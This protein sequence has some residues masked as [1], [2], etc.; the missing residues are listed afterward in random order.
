[1]ATV[2][3]QFRLLARD[4]NWPP[5]GVHWAAAMSFLTLAITC[6]G[7]ALGSVARFAILHVSGPRL[8][9]HAWLVLAMINLVGCLAAGALDGVLADRVTI[10]GLSAEFI[11][12]TVRAGVLGGLTS[13]SA[14]SITSDQ[15]WQSGRPRTALLQALLPLLLAIPVYRL[16]AQCV[17]VC[18]LLEPGGQP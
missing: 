14:L 11:R 6:A 5:P 1:V 4:M 7:G 9:K 10:G 13:F 3:P 12:A 18:G 2:T 17:L 16:G 15:L 8:G